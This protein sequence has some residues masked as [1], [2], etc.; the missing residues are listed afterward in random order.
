MNKEHQNQPRFKNLIQAHIRKPK[1]NL[2]LKT[3]NLNQFRIKKADPTNIQQPK[4]YNK[5]WRSNLRGKNKI[6]SK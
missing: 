3:E 1:S 2:D 6:V 5:S 4:S